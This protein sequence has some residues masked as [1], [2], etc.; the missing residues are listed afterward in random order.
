MSA[1][2]KA[3]REELNANNRAQPWNVSKEELEEMLGEI[4]FEVVPG[5]ESWG[6]IGGRDKQF[7]DG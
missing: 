1:T 2:N 7:I 3:N 5:K 4:K 6:K